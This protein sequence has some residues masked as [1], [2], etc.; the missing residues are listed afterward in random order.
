MNFKQ[1][2][3]TNFHKQSDSF[4]LLISSNPDTLLLWLAEI[5]THSIGV[6]LGKHTVNI[7]ID[8]PNVGENCN[9]IGYAKQEQIEILERIKTFKVPLFKTVSTKDEADIYISIRKIHVKIKS[10]RRSTL[11][12]KWFT[13]DAFEKMYDAGIK[14]LDQKQLSMP[15]FDSVKE[16]GMVP[17]DKIKTDSPHGKILNAPGFI[18]ESALVLFLKSLLVA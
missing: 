15:K 1:I 6:P 17:S 16:L 9:L 3:M 10:Y 18:K 11:L 2:K 4:R 5:M 14:L 7:F 8:K 13:T 12:V